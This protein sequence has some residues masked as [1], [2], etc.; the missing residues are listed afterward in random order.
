TLCAN[1][2]E[3]DGPEVK[4]SLIWIIGEHAEKID[5]AA[6]LLG[7]FV[8]SFI[9]ESYSVQL[10]L[11]MLTTVVKLSLNACDS[12]DLRDRAYIHWRL[13]STDPGAAR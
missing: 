6:E 9:E 13:M 3:L 5:N 8:D 2:D 4:A 12:L 1:L 7:V 10:Q 11:Q